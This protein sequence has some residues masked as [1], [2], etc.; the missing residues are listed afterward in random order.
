MRYHTCFMV[1][2]SG[3]KEYSFISQSRQESSVTL[4]L[5]KIKA[6]E[7]S[8]IESLLVNLFMQ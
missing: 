1:G 4:A 8:E 3:M 7:N 6:N 2:V 5:N